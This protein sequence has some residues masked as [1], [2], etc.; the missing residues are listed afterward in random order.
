MN[1][2]NTFLHLFSLIRKFDKDLEK[3][4]FENYFQSAVPVQRVALVLAILLYGAFGIL[5]IWIVPESRDIVWFIRFAIVIPLL[6][7][8]LTL[9]FYNFYKRYLSLILSLIGLVMGL[10]IVIMVAV[11]Q[12]QE[13]GYR[14]YYA[15]LMLVI[16]WIYILVRIRFIFATVTAVLITLAYEWVGI[17][18]HRM[19]YD[20]DEL[21]VFINNNFFFLSANIIGMFASFAIESFQ[22]RN[23][24]LRNEVERAF[25]M[26]RKYLENINEGLLL[27]DASYLIQSQYSEYLKKLFLK[28]EISQRNLVDLIFPDVVQFS[29]ERK[30]LNKFLHILFHNRHTDI[31]MI[32]DINP[33]KE[34]TILIYPKYGEMRSV[35]IDASYER[36]MKDNEVEYVMIIFRDLTDVVA[37]QKELSDQKSRHQAEIESISAILRQGPEAFTDFFNETNEIL[38]ELVSQIQD[39]QN[40]Q[41]NKKVY[42]QIHTLKGTAKYLE[43]NTI[44][45]IIHSLE[46]RL[47]QFRDGTV[48]PEIKE[49]ITTEIHALLTEF[50]QVE[51]LIER[52]REFSEIPR[53]R[54][55]RSTDKGALQIFFNSLNEMVN[56]IASELGKK[57]EFKTN[58]DLQ[59][60]PLLK[61]VR[62]SIIHIL[63]NALDHGIEDNM[64]RIAAGKGETGVISLVIGMDSDIYRVEITDDGRGI[65]YN[66]IYKK[67]QEKGILKE[68]EPVPEKSRLAR[69]IFSADFSTRSSVTD[70]SGRGV[71]LDAVKDTVQKL[72]GRISINSREKQGTRFILS[73]PSKKGGEEQRAGVAAS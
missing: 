38:N 52:F 16:M 3:Q 20:P 18:V 4:Y 24:L 47:S 7:L 33:L 43:L 26:N 54:G 37:Y 13:L 67:A 31:D 28:D 15:G 62:A 35:V 49:A 5:D 57:V 11:S 48:N 23:F 64:E 22:R 1:L 69:L 21:A 66:K 25:D 70:I 73:I 12:E 6:I 51:L 8:V 36:I 40:S 42:R 44:V 2:K 56:N 17:Y 30:D 41:T 29:Q 32:M 39:L 50:K 46:D 45:G 60:F 55:R 58:S 53:G 59:T 9:S 61:E 72:G 10:G 27:I 71:G 14:Y 34:K 19:I 65:D 63:R 68:G